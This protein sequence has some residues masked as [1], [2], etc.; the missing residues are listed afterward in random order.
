MKSF[1]ELEPKEYDVLFRGLYAPILLKIGLEKDLY[2]D[3]DQDHR[4]IFIPEVAHEIDQR[5]E[6]LDRDS[7]YFCYSKDGKLGEIVC[8]KL[9]KMGMSRPTNLKGGMHAWEE[10]SFISNLAS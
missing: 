5:L 9:A 4:S 3:Q 1:A 2:Q 6:E 8:E 7:F 10:Y